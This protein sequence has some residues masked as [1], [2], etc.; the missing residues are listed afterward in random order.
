MAET[1]LEIQGL[2]CAHGERVVLRDVSFRLA[3]GRVHG[4]L[5]VNGSGKTTLLDHAT[6]HRRPT[7]GR[8]LLHGRDVTGYSRRDL[9]RQIALVP[10]EYG[11]DFDFTAREIVAMGRHPHLPRFA[12]LST[13]DHR[14]VHAAMDAMDVTPLQDRIFSRLSGGEKQRVVAARA[15][16]QDTPLL[17]LDEATAS[18][19]IQHAIRI[20]S[21]IRQRARNQGLTVL[22][23][24]HNLNFAAAYC[25][26]VLIL[27]RGR[28]HRQGLADEVLC[29]ETLEEV[30]AVPCETRFD[31]FSQT[32]QISFQ[33]H[34]DA[35]MA[36]G[37]GGAPP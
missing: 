11:Q 10:Q 35:R 7:A 21:V 6:G 15:L 8:V 26:E 17:M 14:A 36:S 32:R 34:E 16:A 18:L 9:A 13:G 27:H 24:I 2:T 25:D 30:F 1:R 4:L 22:A 33:Y 31:P 23:A 29:R 19:D 5:G 3:P 28:L 37:L 12:S 20:F